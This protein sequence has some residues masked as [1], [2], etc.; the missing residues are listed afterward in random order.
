MGA[1]YHPPKADNALM[2][3][4]LISTMDNISRQHPYT[5]I[6]I[7][8]DF[9]QLPD[10]QLRSYPLRQMVTGPTRKTATLDKIYTNVADWF[11]DPV[12]LP[13][14]T[15]S[16][17]DSVII[18]PSQQGPARPR[19]Q[20]TNI[21]RRSSNS[22]GKAMLCQC[23]KRL[24]WRPLF[25]LQDCA[26]MVDF[27]YS[28]I[29]S[30]LDYY[31]PIIKITKCS[32]DKPWVTPSFKQ[33]IRSRQ[34]AFLSGDTRLYCRL[35]NRTR[36]VASKLRKTYFVAKVEHSNDPHQWWTKT[37]RILNL[38]DSNPL[39][40]LQFQG[41]PDKLANAINE[42]FVSV[43]RHLPKVDPTILVELNNDYCSDFIID[44]VEVANR[45]ASIKCL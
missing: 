22:N 43:S 14:I 18:A 34:R 25:N 5:G 26:A 39:S 16:D 27:F 29:L 11:E 28:T 38:Q 31:L 17:H 9:N 33:L 36:R 7:L 10:G 37:K 15:K 30:L 44:P 41:T 45:L 12:V 19:R 2:I 13:A 20:T 32:T 6:M 21:Y 24:D 1:I 35:R 40:N 4:H 23:L 8:G 42:F 3:E